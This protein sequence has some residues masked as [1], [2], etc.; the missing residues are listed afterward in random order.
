[1]GPRRQYTVE[2]GGQN[3]EYRL[4][5][6]NMNL[7]VVS[8]GGYRGKHKKSEAGISRAVDPSEN[9]ILLAWP[10]E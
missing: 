7:T 3:F 1:M 5:L 9:F 10:V 6:K 4:R 8:T 2:A